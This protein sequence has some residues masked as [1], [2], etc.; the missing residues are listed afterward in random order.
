MPSLGPRKSGPLASPSKGT[1]RGWGAS[2]AAPSSPAQTPGRLSWHGR[3]CDS[4]VRL[5]SSELSINSQMEGGIDA[6]RSSLDWAASSKPYSPARGPA[7]GPPRD[8][9]Q[10]LHSQDS[11][12]LMDRAKSSGSA[13]SLKS[14]E[15]GLR[16]ERVKSASRA[17]SPKGH[18]LASPMERAESSGN[19]V[20][21][22]LKA[23]H[24]DGLQPAEQKQHHGG[25]S[26][27]GSHM[28]THDSL[29]NTASQHGSSSSSGGVS[30]AHCSPQHLPES[31]P[32]RS[33]GGL[34]QQ[35]PQQQ[36][37]GKRGQAP[38]MPQ[39]AGDF[40]DQ[41]AHTEGQ[42]CSTSDPSLVPLIQ[43]SES[44]QALQEQGFSLAGSTRSHAEPSLHTSPQRDQDV[45]PSSR[46]DSALAGHAAACGHLDSSGGAWPAGNDG[47]GSHLVGPDEQAHAAQAQSSSDS[48][49]W[50]DDRAGERPF[51]AFT[52]QKN[53]GRNIS[54]GLGCRCQEQGFQVEYGE[55]VCTP[56]HTPWC[57]MLLASV[58]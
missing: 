8:S 15:A 55:Q 31:G 26:S 41:I 28:A 25:H 37:E 17:D 50:D 45:Q 16:M 53:Q 42:T 13:G 6:G 1:S 38:Q 7:R 49:G 40:V 58:A 22:D 56:C 3:E 10:S 32:P 2:P 29:E 46:A 20:S 14:R 11:G 35:Q 18:D 9:M 51:P 54:G 47:A 39:P 5:T 4:V 52:S 33:S 12:S 19:V 57:A 48:Q 34:Q 36:P 21:R 27:S 44:P 43:A 23:S 24:Q 30:K